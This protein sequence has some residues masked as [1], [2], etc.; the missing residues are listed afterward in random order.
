ME[1]PDPKMTKRGAQAQIPSQ[2]KND[3]PR[4]DEENRIERERTEHPPMRE[5]R[6]AQTLGTRGENAPPLHSTQTH[7]GIGAAVEDTEGQQK[8]NAKVLM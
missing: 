6:I 1:P 3:T 8:T 2:R 7:L 4:W 5:L